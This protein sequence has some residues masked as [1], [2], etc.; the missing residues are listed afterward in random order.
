MPQTKKKNR[1]PTLASPLSYVLLAG[2]TGL[3]AAAGC[4]GEDTAGPASVFRVKPE[5]VGTHCQYGGLRIEYGTDTNGNL[6]LDDNEVSASQT[7][8]ACAILAEG[9]TSKVNVVDEPLGAH[10]GNG[11]YRL[12]SGL[13]KDNDGTLEASEIESTAYVC[14]GLNAVNGMVKVLDEPKGANCAN[15]G[16]KILSGL[17]RNSNGLLEDVEVTSTEYTCN[18]VDAVNGIVRVLAEPAGAHCGNGGQK[19]LAGLDTN[20]NQVL[21]DSEATSTSYVCNGVNSLT[22]LSSLPS[23]PNPGANQCLFGGTKVDSGLDLN[24]DGTLQSTEVQ[25]TSVVCSVQVLAN[26]IVESYVVNMGDPTTTCANGGVRMNA[27]VDMNGDHHLQAGEIT[28]SVDICNQVQLISGKNSLIKTFN[29]TSAQCAWGGYVIQSGQDSNYNNV[30]E[31]SETQSTSV[32]CNGA[33]GFNSLVK[34][35][36]DNSAAGCGAKGGIL[37]QSGLDTDRDNVLDA[38]EVTQTGYICNGFTG[39]Q[40]PEGVPSLIKQSADTSVCGPRGGVRIDSGADTN[41]DSLLQNS[42]IDF[43]SFVCNGYDGQDGY[44]YNSLVRPTAISPGST[45]GAGGVRYD[46]GLDLNANNY[47]DSNEVDYSSYVCHGYDGENGAS[48]S[49]VSIEDASGFACEYGGVEINV[50]IDFDYDG[51]LDSSEIDSTTYLCAPEPL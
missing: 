12:E 22:R 13:D 20:R 2:L 49:L 44:S 32:V 18:G 26:V 7:E 37:F 21:E 28:S 34:Q 23:T 31:A 36:P 4:S 41:R 29:A 5:A 14:N 24:G 50:G 47:L 43:T 9:K 8:Y 27:G 33:N 40:G 35:T 19:I 1:I 10:C 3:L 6:R 25:T 48:G 42:E 11:G 17:D 15:A 46:T 45:C 39:P 30:L 51:Y 16:Q 38:V